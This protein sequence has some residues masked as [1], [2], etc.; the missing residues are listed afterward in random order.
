MVE[1]IK[2]SIKVFVIPKSFLAFEIYRIEIEIKDKISI[3]RLSISIVSMKIIIYI[4]SP[5][6]NLA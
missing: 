2:I 3:D 6:S 1:R 4:N 5:K